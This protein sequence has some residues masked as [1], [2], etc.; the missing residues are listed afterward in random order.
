MKVFV[1]SILVAFT[2]LAYASEHANWSCASAVAFDKHGVHAGQGDNYFAARGSA[3]RACGG[4]HA[5]GCVPVP[6]SCRR[7]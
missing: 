4:A 6:F 1:A 5:L 7:D 3:Q 2:I